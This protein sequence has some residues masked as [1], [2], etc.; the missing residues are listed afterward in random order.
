LSVGLVGRRNGNT[1]L[2]IGLSTLIGTGS[3]PITII[4]LMLVLVLPVGKFAK[5]LG[6]INAATM[7]SDVAIT[8][9]TI[10]MITMWL[11]V[12]VTVGVTLL[13]VTITKPREKNLHGQ[14]SEHTM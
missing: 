3:S 7:P 10:I 11:V 12:G 8:L 2:K 4:P 5:R 6:V 1:I 9:S 13:F 14:I